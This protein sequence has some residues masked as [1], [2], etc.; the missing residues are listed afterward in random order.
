MLEQFLDVRGLVGDAGEGAELPGGQSGGHA[1]LTHR[2]CL[3]GS[4]AAAGI[5]PL[6]RGDAV[7]EA[8][9]HRLRTIGDRPAPHC[10]DQIRPR[11]PRLGRR[12]DD[13]GAGSVGG[14]FIEQAHAAI[15]QS[16][17][18]FGDLLGFAVEGAADHQE[19][20]LRAQMADLLDEGGGGGLAVD[21]RVHLAER[22]FSRNGHGGR[23]SRRRCVG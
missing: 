4:V 5:Q 14:H 12:R 3:E 19:H 6:D 1:D 20:P 13:G 8:K 17:A 23:C 2:G 7:G 10:H 11:L 9:L 15:A 16:G 21:D 22:D 18:D